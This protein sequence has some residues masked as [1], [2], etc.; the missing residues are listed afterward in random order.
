MNATLHQQVV[1]ITENYLGPAAPRFID[2]QIEFH[3]KKKPDELTNQDLPQLV[4]WVKV[5]LALLTDDKKM[6]DECV[7][8]LGNL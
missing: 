5:S 6:V 8:K 1:G 2:R 4:E 3:L 7:D